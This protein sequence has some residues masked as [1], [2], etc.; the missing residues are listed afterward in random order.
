MDA[1][2]KI[3]RAFRKWFYRN[4][5]CCVTL[6][7]VQYPCFIYKTS[8][9]CIFYNYIALHK[10]FKISGKF[11]DPKT[12]NK[13]SNLEIKRFK[14]EL[15]MHFPNEDTTYYKEWQPSGTIN[16][17]ILDIFSFTIVPSS[18][19]DYATLRAA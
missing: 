15:K 11:V 1:A 13:Y 16:V 4:A 9:V 14:K 6:E 17:S 2:I 7:K 19:P 8:G 5:I 3:Q 18:R 10:Y 12:R